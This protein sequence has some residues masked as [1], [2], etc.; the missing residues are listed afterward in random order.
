MKW[1]TFKK[2]M[3]E[4]HLNWE[5]VNTKNSFNLQKAKRMGIINGIDNILTN[6]VIMFLYEIRLRE[7]V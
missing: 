5:R 1:L 2:I 3:K 6:V 4:D 7:A